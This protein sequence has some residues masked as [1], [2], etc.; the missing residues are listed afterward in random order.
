MPPL[1]SHFLEQ[2]RFKAVAPYISGDIL[3][4]GCNTG[5]IIGKLQPNQNY[6]GIDASPEIIDWLYTYRKGYKFHR[7][8]LD[9]DEIALSGQFDTILMLAVIEH[10]VNPGN[11]LRQIPRYLNKGGYL[12]IT[13]PTQLGDRLHRVGAKVSLTSTVA[14]EDHEHIY[15]YPDMKACLTRN[16]LNIKKYSRFLLG[17]NQLFVCEAGGGNIS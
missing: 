4:L 1:L 17:G 6:V 11:I 5:W 2:Q 13:T 15:S 16:G 8:D 10:L 3:D 14:V 7:R 9:R 12:L